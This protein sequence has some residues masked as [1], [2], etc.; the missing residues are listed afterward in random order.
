[1]LLTAQGP[2]K[3]IR[4]NA[5][6]YHTAAKKELT[7][8]ARVREIQNRFLGLWASAAL[9][10]MIAVFNVLIERLFSSHDDADSSDLGSAP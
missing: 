4:Q 7:R 8:I 5:F 9:A 10:L 1:L 3:H 6:R 2:G